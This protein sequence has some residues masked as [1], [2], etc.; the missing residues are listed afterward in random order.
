M[1]I[2]VVKFGGSSLANDES[3]K[4]VAKKIIGFLEKKQKVVAILSAQGKTTDFLLKEASTLSFFPNKRNLDV[5]LSTGEQISCSKFAIL[6]NEMGIPATC[7]TGWQ[8]GIL[9]D[10]EF[11]SA[12]IQ[13][14]YPTRIWESLKDNDVVIITGFQGIDRN[15]NI[16][17]L[18]RDGSDT[19]A[20][21]IAAALEQKQCYI[22]T[23][24]DGIY[25]KDPNQFPEAKRIPKLSYE[26]M[27]D[28]AKT[29]A[30][31]LHDRCIRIAKKYQIKIIVASSFEEKEGSIVE[32]DNLKT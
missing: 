1:E 18:G 10:S 11:G 28:L 4:K 15:G 13:D 7:L 25:D 20:V 5:L 17:T 31:V 23:D 24:T 6:L 12:K 3:L 9:T 30:K 14:I 29:G 21:A 26:Q 19:T 32:N 8:S 16:T 22:F 2:Q 27:E